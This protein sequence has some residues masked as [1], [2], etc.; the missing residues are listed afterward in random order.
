MP[1]RVKVPSAADAVVCPWI[2][3]DTVAGAPS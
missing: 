3:T 1:A 2:V